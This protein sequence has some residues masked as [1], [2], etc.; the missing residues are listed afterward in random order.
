MNK[1]TNFT[2][3]ILG[4]ILVLVAIFLWNLFPHSYI[5]GITGMILIVVGIYLGLKVRK[6]I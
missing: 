6:Q 4:G 5:S 2:L 1:N 3:L